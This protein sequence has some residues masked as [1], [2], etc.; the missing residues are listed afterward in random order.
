MA[1]LL[2]SVD[3]AT[4]WDEADDRERRVLIG[5]LVDAVYVYPAHL[6]VLACGA[7]PLKVEL[8]EVGLRS[9]AGMGTFV[10]EGG[11]EPPRP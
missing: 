1:G 6:R 2:D 5:Y 8:T 7:P 9:P 10:S 11:L 4:V 3:I